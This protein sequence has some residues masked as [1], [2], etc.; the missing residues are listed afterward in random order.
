MYHPSRKV[1]LIVLGL[2]IMLV[3]SACSGRKSSNSQGRDKLVI[4][5]STALQPLI[6]EAARQYR[7]QNPNVEITVQ[8]GGSGTGMTQVATGTA[9]I[10]MSDITIE[11][12]PELMNSG[13]VDHEIAIIGFAVVVHPKVNVTNLSKEQVR[14]IFSGK[15]TNW[16][17]LGGAD[18]A[19]VVVNRPEGSGTRSTFNR[20]FMGDEKAIESIAQD[21]SGAIRRTISDTPGA[22][23][24]LSFSYLNDN[25]KT[26][27]LNGV[28]PTVENILEN[29]YSF[30][31]YE[32]LYTKGEASP[33][34]Q[35]FID[36]ILSTD[37]Q[38]TI[39]PK[40]KL[41]TVTTTDQ[42]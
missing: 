15:I 19:I 32:H 9:D 20:I 1:V 37:I 38:T 22:I 25:V 17:A 42:K 16:K 33:A 30:W 2:C 18:Q 3:L 12:R 28:A 26:L 23:G 7:G 39:L 5:G 31:A 14:D 40:M 4:L 27:H 24:Y 41:I 35:S 11:E 13:L 8:G 34:A 10:G 6:E 36:F 21:S 29:K